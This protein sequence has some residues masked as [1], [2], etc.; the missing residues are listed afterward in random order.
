LL[1]EHTL[2]VISSD[3][4]HYHPYAEARQLDQQTVDAIHTLDTGKMATQEACGRVP[5][6]TLLHLAKRYGWQPK[7]LDF[8]SSGDT[9]GDKSRVVGYAAVALYAPDVDLDLNAP[10]RA[11]LLHI[12]REAVQDATRSTV[13]TKLD[14]PRSPALMAHKGV[15]VTLTKHGELRGCIGH[16]VSESPLYLTVQECAREAAIHDSRFSPVTTS[17]FNDLEIEISLLTAPKPLAFASASDLLK[18]LRPK[19][20]GVVL[21]IA[22]GEATY[23]PQVWDDLRDKI[24]FLD[25]LSEKAGGR[26]GDWRRPGTK[27]MVYQVSSF[28]DGRK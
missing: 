13:S 27:V 22:S 8:R 7:L 11:T 19:I 28:G 6:L 1:T 12:A 24:E 23:L 3:L 10:D 15:F 20:D 16:L 2:L 18:Q 25:S 17:E 9:S 26:A 5:I 21:Q 4:S 14:I